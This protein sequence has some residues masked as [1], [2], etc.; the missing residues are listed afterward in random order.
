MKGLVLISVQKIAN[1]LRI[2]VATAFA[3]LAQPPKIV[4]Q[5]DARKAS[6]LDPAKTRQNVQMVASVKVGPVLDLV[7]DRPAH[8]P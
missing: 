3:K 6:A 4:R 1:V 8:L 2:C 7:K 5:A